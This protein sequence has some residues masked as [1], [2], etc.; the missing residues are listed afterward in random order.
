MT[1]FT[2]TSYKKVTLEFGKTKFHKK[3]SHFPDRKNHRIKKRLIPAIDFIFP[4]QRV[5]MC[6]QSLT[7]NWKRTGVSS[8]NIVN[9]SPCSRYVEGG[10]K[11]GGRPTT[12]FCSV[13]WFESSSSTFF[14][15]VSCDPISAFRSIKPTTN[16]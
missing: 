9:I 7:P 1:K 13:L 2:Y 3:A 15:G 8:S 5:H 11:Y 4:P 16:L 6:Y 12:N 14:S 10:H